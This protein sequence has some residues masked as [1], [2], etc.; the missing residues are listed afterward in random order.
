MMNN[1]IHLLSSDY[2]MKSKKKKN[3]HATFEKKGICVV[4]ILKLMMM[5]CLRIGQKYLTLY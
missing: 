4:I 1:G 2:E 3:C 5:H